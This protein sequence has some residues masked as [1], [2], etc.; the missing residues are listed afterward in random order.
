RPRWR[1]PR[2]LG[3]QPTPDRGGIGVAAV[4]LGGEPQEIVGLGIVGAQCD[5]AL[6]FGLGVRGDDTARGTRKGFAKIG[7][8]LG[9]VAVIGDRI[10]IGAYRLVETAEPRQ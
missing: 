9:A 2:R 5:G 8:A 1:A 7:P 6:E 4:L 3:K 10:A